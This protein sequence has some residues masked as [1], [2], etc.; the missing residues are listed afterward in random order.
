MEPL[1]VLVVGAGAA[2]LAAAHALQRAGARLRVIE[3]RDRI[4]GRVATRRD[5]FDEIPFE[6]GAEFV[7]GVPP[8]T[9]RVAAEAGLR[10]E[11]VDGAHRCLR[12]GALG[13]CAEPLEAATALLARHEGADEPIA[14]K[15]RRARSRSG[16][17]KDVAELAAGFVEG[18]YAAPPDEASAAAIAAMEAAAADHEGSRAFRV[19]EGYDR[20]LR[21]L[22]Q[23]LEPGSLLLNAVA[24]EV[25]W[26]RGSVE[27]RVASRRGFPLEPLQARAAIVTVPV[28]VLKARPGEPGA[29]SEDAVMV[30][31]VDADHFVCRLRPADATVQGGVPASRLQAFASSERHAEIDSRGSGHED[32]EGK[33][34]RYRY[35]FP[36]RRAQVARS[37]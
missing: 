21:A 30:G 23:R 8:T 35:S 10:I 26:R 28:G 13:D 1:D 32:R 33:V 14:R 2:G 36:R 31:F 20:V 7:H 12:G 4:G 15:L 17:S 24:R 29:N 3:A 11:E 22:A 27:L 9:C 34:P 37:V 19:I 5:L 16:L 18:F 25:R 6:M